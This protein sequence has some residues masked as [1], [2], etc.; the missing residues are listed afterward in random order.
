MDKITNSELMSR[1]SNTIKVFR[2]DDVISV[3]IPP[4]INW[5]GVTK[6]LVDTAD[7]KVLTI[8]L[9]TMTICGYE[10]DIVA[11]SDDYFLIRGE[12]NDKTRHETEAAGT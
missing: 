9:K 5:Y 2:T 8:G 6:E 7:E 1:I 10:F 12:H 4:G 3:E 11:H